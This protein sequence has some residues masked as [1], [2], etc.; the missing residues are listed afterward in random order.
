MHTLTNTAKMQQ[1]IAVISAI[2]EAPI[3]M[4]YLYFSSLD[5][6]HGMIFA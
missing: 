1:A 3:G 5:D 4:V 6:F 2:A